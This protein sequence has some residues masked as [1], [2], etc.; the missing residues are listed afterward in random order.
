MEYDKKFNDNR[1]N[2]KK[3]TDE[4]NVYIQKNNNENTL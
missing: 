4:S 2:R 1:K 3:I